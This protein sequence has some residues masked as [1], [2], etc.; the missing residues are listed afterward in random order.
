MKSV[1]KCELCFITVDNMYDYI[2]I[3]YLGIYKQRFN[4]H[5]PI[6]HW[7]P[8]KKFSVHTVCTYSITY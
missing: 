5:R 1:I 4:R 2:D 7:R 3:I 6:K 8:H